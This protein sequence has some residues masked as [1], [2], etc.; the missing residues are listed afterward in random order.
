MTKQPPTDQEI[1]D[2]MRKLGRTALEEL[3]RRGVSEAVIQKAL[4]PKKSG[5]GAVNDQNP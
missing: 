3:R 1:A 4:A 2:K 5:R